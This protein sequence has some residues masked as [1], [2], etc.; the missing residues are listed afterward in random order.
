MRSVYDS[1]AEFFKVDG[2]ALN[3][4]F[5]SEPAGVEQ[6]DEIAT[7]E[8]GRLEAFRL[9]TPQRVAR[10]RST[11]RERQRHRSGYERAANSSSG[12]VGHVVS[13]CRD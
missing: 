13:R 7:F 2:G 10:L 12:Q 9:A 8:G 11:R 1:K 6:R 3:E 4:R 5:I